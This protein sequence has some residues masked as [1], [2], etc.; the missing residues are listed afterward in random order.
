MNTIAAQEIKRRGV[1]AVDSFVDRGPVHIVKSNRPCYVVMTEA[2]YEAMLDDL[3]E[4]RLAASEADLRA[5]RCRRGNATQ[6][7]REIRKGE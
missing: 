7:I 3:A 4:A 5:G 6:L 2:D 1:A